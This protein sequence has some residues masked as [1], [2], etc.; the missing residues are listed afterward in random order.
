[1]GTT[2]KRR[3]TAAISLLLIVTFVGVF[4]AIQIWIGKRFRELDNKLAVMSPRT[5]ISTEGD[6]V[7]TLNEDP[8]KTAAILKIASQRRRPFGYTVGRLELR[9]LHVGLLD[10]NIRIED[11]FSV[12]TSETQPI[13]IREAQLLRKS[14]PRCSLWTLPRIEWNELIQKEFE[15]FPAGS[16]IYCWDVAPPE[17][18]SDHFITIGNAGI[19]WLGKK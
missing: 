5:Y 11:V 18:G 1:M 12:T 16:S 13:G 3:I 9:N 10:E 14:F 4:W 2:R 6:R 15:Q 8:Q 7:I 19:A 17:L